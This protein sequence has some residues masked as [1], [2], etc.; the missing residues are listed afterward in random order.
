[1]NRLLLISFFYFSPIPIDKID[2]S[3]YDLR[4]HPDFHFKSG[5]LIIHIGA[6]S[7]PGMSSLTAGQVLNAG[8]DGRV[9]FFFN[10]LYNIICYSIFYGLTVILI[11]DLCE[12]GK[13]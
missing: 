9:F 2:F 10:I 5:C 7:N 8:S 12:M 11:L 13:R 6:D 1:M 4:D 3:V